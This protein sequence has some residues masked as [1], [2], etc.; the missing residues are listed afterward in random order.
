MLHAVL[1]MFWGP[2]TKP[3][4]EGLPDLT[5][6]EGIALL[7]LVLLIFYIGLFP[8]KM[9]GDMQASVDTFA[10]EYTAKLAAGDQH[11]DARDIL[12]RKLVPA[13]ALA[14]LGLPSGEKSARLDAPAR[15]L[16]VQLVGGAQ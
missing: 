7:P 14:P 12:E 3:E 9:L 5:R 1:K 6:R 4:N 16:P 11:P 13:A 8:G 2:I 15:T 10:S